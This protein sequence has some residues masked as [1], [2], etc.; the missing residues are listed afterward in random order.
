MKEK[1]V[2]ILLSA[3]NGEK[4][5]KEQIDSLISQTYSKIHIYIRD[6]GSKDNTLSIIKHYAKN[7]ENITIMEGENYGFVKSFFALLKAVEDAD[8]YAF[9]DQDDVWREDKIQRSVDMLSK[10]NENKPNLFF[11][12]SDYYDIDLNFVANGE[13][14]KIYNFR[15]SL[16]ECVSQG[17]TMCINKTAR[18]MLIENEP[19]N[20]ISH[21]CWIYMLCSGLGQ[22]V[23]DKEALV[24]YRRHTTS[25]T[26][27]GKDFIEFQ[28]WRIK[29][30]ILNDSLKLIKKQLIEFGNIYIE[31]LNDEDKKVME[32]FMKEKYTFP[33]SI[34][35]AFYPKKFRKKIIDEIL[36]RILFLVGMM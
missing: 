33:L 25:V 9:C 2:A 1:S 10:L 12:N 21:D 19:K 7:N 14:N 22:M 13:Q 30:F 20:C 32:L 8:Y 26:A 36:L 34:K 3:Y 31:Q 28:I 24:K 11:S 29:K 17:M 35:K 4:Y 18:N 27:E 16:V 23:Y 15:N 6:D 5:I